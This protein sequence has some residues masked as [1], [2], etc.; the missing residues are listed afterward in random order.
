VASV[1]LVLDA[2]TYERLVD[3]AVS[4]RRPIP[5]QVEVILRRALNLPFPYPS[6]SEDSLIG[7]P[8]TRLREQVTV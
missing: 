1:K 2:E 4:E 7:A 6:E 5:W 3:Q 8:G